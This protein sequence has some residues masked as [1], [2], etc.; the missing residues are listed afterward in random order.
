MHLKKKNMRNQMKIMIKEK[1][2]LEI[3]DLNI[4]IYGLAI[5]SY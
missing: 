4:Y 1:I 5:F 3:T 2:I